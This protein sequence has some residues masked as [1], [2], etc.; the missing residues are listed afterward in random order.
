MPW[1]R[2]STTSVGAGP[3]SG[4]SDAPG[5]PE[6]VDIAGDGEN[7]RVVVGAESVGP[8]LHEAVHHL[9]AGVAS[10]RQQPFDV[11]H[12]LAARLLGEDGQSRIRT[13]DRALAFLCDDRGVCGR[14]EIGEADSHTDVGTS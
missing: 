7:L 12:R 4:S 13:H 2:L 8:P 3:S 11:G 9:H 1:E 10:R 14:R 6:C 5:L